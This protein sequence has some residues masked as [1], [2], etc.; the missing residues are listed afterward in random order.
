VRIMFRLANNDLEAMLTAQAMENSGVEVFS[1]TYIGTAQ[2]GSAIVPSARFAV[3][4]KAKSDKQI[5]AAD[6]AI[7]KE[8][9]DAGI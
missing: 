8:F 2:L 6:L 7:N 1:I 3:W 4:A 5:T 9:T